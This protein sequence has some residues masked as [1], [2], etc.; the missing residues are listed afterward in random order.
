MDE[1]TSPHFRSPSPGSYKTAGFGSP[2][3]AT[4]GGHLGSENGT[5]NEEMSS[6]PN[7][8]DKYRSLTQNSHP[9]FGECPLEPPE[10]SGVG[11]LYLTEAVSAEISLNE[12]YRKIE[13]VLSPHCANEQR[14][15]Q[16]QQF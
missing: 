6:G 1:Y 13:Q 15:G 2:G 12:H 9:E 14:L 4:S 5:E 10:Q 16:K 8:L 7:I 11:S 3:S